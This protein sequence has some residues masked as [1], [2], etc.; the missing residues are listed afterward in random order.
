MNN[1]RKAEDILLYFGDWSLD[2]ES[3]TYLLYHHRRYEFLLRRVD[4]IVAK[5]QSES[6][7]EA[8][9]ILDVGPGFQT[10]ILRK[11]LP[12]AIVNTLGF[13]DTRFTPRPQ[14]RHFQ[15]DLNDAQ[16]QERWPTV[17]RHDLVIL[18]EVI[19]HLYTYPVLVLKCISTWLR[20][21]GYLLVQTPNAC[22]LHK[23]IRMLM[24]RNPYDMIRETRDNPGHFREYTIKE[25]ISIANQ[26]GFAL[27]EY[28]TRNYF[29]NG[30]TQQ[31]LYDALSRILPKS[32]RQGVTACFRKI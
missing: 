2:K 16:Y 5:I 13:E 7:D 1:L 20:R 11:T 9:N 18:A 23:R 25:L 17:E 31:K 30:T 19:E 4:W 22:A 28:T 14:D 15:F 32:L 24:G 8:M 21:G 3:R 26:S 12:E 10:E 6:H 27:I 29:D